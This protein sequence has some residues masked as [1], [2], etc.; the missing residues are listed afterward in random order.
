MK[1]MIYIITARKNNDEWFSENLK[2]DVEGI[3]R[4]WL[5]DIDIYYDRIFFNFQV[6]PRV[7]SQNLHIIILT[8]YPSDLSDRR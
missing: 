4:R 6:V 2:N 3:T 7:F 1:T 8:E 5:N